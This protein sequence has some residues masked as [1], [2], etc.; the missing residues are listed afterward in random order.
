[1]SDNIELREQ[2]SPDDL[3]VS[4]RIDEERSNSGGSGSDSEFHVSG[5]AVGHH[6]GVSFEQHQDRTLGS[7]IPR[8]SNNNS[9]RRDAENASSSDSLESLEVVPIDGQNNNGNR[10]ERQVNSPATGNVQQRSNLQLSGFIET[11]A[12]ELVSP[13]NPTVS[14]M[15]RVRRADE[16]VS[17][18]YTSPENM[19][20]DNLERI[21]QRSRQRQ[22]HMAA[23]RH[24]STPNSGRG[25]PAVSIS[26]AESP[27]PIEGQHN[28]VENSHNETINVNTSLPEILKP[29]NCHDDFKKF[30]G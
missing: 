23:A 3:Y 7:D 4:A 25:V 20:Q 17:Y 15:F 29:M 22:Q 28:N 8:N 5:V 21:T 1:M 24:T 9:S 18:T 16:G 2:N 19:V 11:P 14:H 6:S 30:P 12:D 26:N 10:S 27:A 13:G